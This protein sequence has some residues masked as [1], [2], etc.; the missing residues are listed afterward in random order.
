MSRRIREASVVLLPVAFLV[1]LFVAFSR[2]FFVDGWMDGC[3]DGWMDGCRALG[4]FSP[5]Q[6]RTREIVDDDDDEIWD[7]EIVRGHD[8]SP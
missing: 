7:C 2:S 3:M 6:R 5:S 1:D 4:A 8:F